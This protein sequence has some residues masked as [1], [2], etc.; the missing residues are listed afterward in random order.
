[1]YECVYPSIYPPFCLAIHMFVRQSVCPS[2]NNLL[3]TIA[4]LHVENNVMV[5]CHFLC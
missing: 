4:L 2:V 5:R 1:M 3:T